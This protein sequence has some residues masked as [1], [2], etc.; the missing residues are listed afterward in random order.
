L[1]L[2]LLLGGWMILA[3]VFA[4]VVEML[5]SALPAIHLVAVGLSILS[6]LLSRGTM[7]FDGIGEPLQLL[8]EAAFTPLPVSSGAMAR[9]KGSL[10]PAAY[11][12]AG[13]EGGMA[14]LVLAGLLGRVLLPPPS[15][16][17][18]WYVWSAW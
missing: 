11:E 4:H 3:A 12:V 8:L 14:P 1:V 7:V 18:A 15:S 6:A 9:R 13:V 5:R 17:S 16:L 2:V 10:A